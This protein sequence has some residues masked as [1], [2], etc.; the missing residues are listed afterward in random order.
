M[1]PGT[2]ASKRCAFSLWTTCSG[3]ESFMMGRDV[4]RAKE[5]TTVTC[6]ATRHADRSHPAPAG[7]GLAVRR[8]RVG[9]ARRGAPVR[10]AAPRTQCGACVAAAHLLPAV[11][12]GAAL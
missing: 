5:V 9:V 6:A 2:A 12:G 1:P 7:L 11:A 3:A 10:P 4:E 8:E